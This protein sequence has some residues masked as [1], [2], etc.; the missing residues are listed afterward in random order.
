M[1]IFH[2]LELRFFSYDDTFP[3]G[4]FLY[5]ILLPWY[6]KV[7]HFMLKENHPVFPHKN[8]EIRYVPAST[9]FHHVFYKVVRNP[10][11]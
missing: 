10:F 3:V 9:L 2:M 8:V 5:F 7:G 1:I 6:G 4:T 11:F